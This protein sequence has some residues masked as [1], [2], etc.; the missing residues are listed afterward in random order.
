MTYLQSLKKDDEIGVF[1][2][3]FI[4]FLNRIKPV[5]SETALFCALVAVHDQLNGNICTDLEKLEESLLAKKIGL[6]EKS[7]L[8][9]KSALESSGFVGS[10]GE[11]KPLILEGNRLYIHKLWSFEAE[12]VTW[13]KAKTQQSISAKNSVIAEE[14]NKVF[15]NST[16]RDDLQKVATCLALFKPFLIIS[17]GPGTGKTYT[18]KKIL[19]VLKSQ[20]PEVKI[21]LAAPTGKAAERLNESITDLNEE[22]VVSTLHKLL[23]SRRNGE[24]RFNEKQKLVYDIVIVDEASMLDI[25]MWVSLTRALKNTARL[26]VLGD[27]DQLASVEAGSVLGDICWTANNSF[28]ENTASILKQFELTVEESTSSNIINDNIV[29]LTKSYRS[30]SS[31][32]IP[33]LAVSINEQDFE[34]FMDI[35]EESDH[36]KIQE[37][38]SRDIEE[39]VRSYSEEIINLVSRTQFLCS[40]R[41]G[42][43]GTE[44]LNKLVESNLKS[45]LG[46]PFSQE[47]YEGRRVLTTK[48]N[49][50]L[51]ISNGEIGTCIK[52]TDGALVVRFGNSRDIHTAELSDFDLAYAIT[53]HKSQGS[54]FENVCI[55]ISDKLNPVLSKELLYTG[56]TRAKESALVIGR[57]EIIKQMIL[58]E[59]KRS[60]AIPEKIQN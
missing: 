58:K 7:T 33:Q 20:N 17:G 18:V 9:L 45:I 53:I 36:I 32:G 43:F 19:S 4:R 28:N 46:I 16:D 15:I 44:N 30:S 54:E 5:E 31:T 12:L 6:T 50:R 14:L 8:V 29:L 47:W 25:R 52:Q 55:F 51:G 59:I 49:A 56:V 48:N 39:L 1:E 60:S 2:L 38:I 27:K 21:A 37:P 3:E 26:I 42:R 40:N 13:L 22:F 35:A 10:V 41:K 34:A 24:F 23:G 11:Y 57:R